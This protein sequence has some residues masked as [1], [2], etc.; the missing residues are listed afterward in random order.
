MA[1]ATKKTATV[2][3]KDDLKYITPE[4]WKKHKLSDL[5]A[6]VIE[7]VKAVVKAGFTIN[8]L[9]WIDTVEGDMHRP[10]T[11]PTQCS[12]CLGGSVIMGFC[13]IPPVK[14]LA[15]DVT[16]DRDGKKTYMIDNDKTVEKIVGKRSTDKAWELANLMDDYRTGGDAGYFAES[17]QSDLKLNDLETIV[18]KE[19]CD[20]EGLEQFNG[21]LSKDQINRLIDQTERIVENLRRFNL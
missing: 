10:I 14:C 15:I 2:K 11:S 8:M 18:V 20:K 12:V 3:V 21:E 1:T 5:L 7:D 9:S 16:E 4:N 17:V 19:I 13:Q 6:S